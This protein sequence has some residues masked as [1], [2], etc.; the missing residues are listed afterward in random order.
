[1]VHFIFLCLNELDQGPFTA[2][3]LPTV[4]SSVERDNI[5]CNRPSDHILTTYLGCC[6]RA[7]LPIE[8]GSTTHLDGLLCQLGNREAVWTGPR[9][10]VLYTRQRT[11]PTRGDPPVPWGHD[12]GY[13][14]ALW[15]LRSLILTP[16]APLAGPAWA[17]AVG[18]ACACMA[19][20]HGRGYALTQSSKYMI[21]RGLIL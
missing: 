4:T 20:D 6:S 11:V 19:T 1:M 16:S 9:M 10:S 2:D 5:Y 13:W 7:V 3:V 21:G 17:L 18:G 12:R 8:F 15:P 14:E